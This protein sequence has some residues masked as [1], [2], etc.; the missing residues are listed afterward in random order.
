MLFPISCCSRSFQARRRSKKALPKSAVLKTNPIAG[1]TSP[2]GVKPSTYAMEDHFED[3][4]SNVGKGVMCMAVNRNTARSRNHS[5][6]TNKRDRI[7]PARG[8][9]VNQAEAMPTSVRRRSDHLIG[10]SY[11]LLRTSLG[12]RPSHRRIG[13]FPAFHSGCFKVCPWGSNAESRYR[14]A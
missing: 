2:N 1:R 5:I 8:P 11:R 4:Y 12:R 7:T 9:S 14:G 10:V 13:R 6:V 3:S